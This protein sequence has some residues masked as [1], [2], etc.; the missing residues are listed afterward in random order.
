MSID[1]PGN[2]TVTHRLGTT[3][4]ASVLAV[5]AVVLTGGSLAISGDSEFQDLTVSR[6]ALQGAGD[7]SISANGRL[8]WTGGTINGG[9]KVIIPATGRLNISGGTNKHLRNRTIGNLGITTWTGGGAI[10][11]GATGCSTTWL[12]V[13]STLRTTSPSSP[14]WVGRRRCSTTWVPS[15]RRWAPELPPWHSCSTTRERSMCK[16]ARSISPGEVPDCLRRLPPLWPSA[17]GR[18]FPAAAPV[19]GP[20]YPGLAATVRTL[21]LN[22]VL[23]TH[24]R[25]PGYISKSPQL[26]LNHW[27][28]FPLRRWLN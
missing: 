21:C 27:A 25:M 24:G 15:R 8:D 17:S 9:G 11:A 18:L 23:P 6:G 2:V 12:E 19:T 7:L 22:M 16:P 1:V 20:S 14:T 26:S 4:I 13:Y 28:S 5:D 10:R 3:T